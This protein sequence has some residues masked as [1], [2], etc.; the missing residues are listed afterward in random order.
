[1]KERKLKMFISNPV[2]SLLKF[3]KRKIY[4]KRFIIFWVTTLIIQMLSA[5]SPGQFQWFAKNM[6]C[7]GAHPVKYSVVM[8][9]NKIKGMLCSPISWKS[10]LDKCTNIIKRLEICK[11]KVFVLDH[12]RLGH[13]R[14]STVIQEKKKS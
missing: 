4:R 12:E 9:F 8:K 10:M 6:E 7:W 5:I 3:L 1:M 13:M 14:M 11:K 2:Q